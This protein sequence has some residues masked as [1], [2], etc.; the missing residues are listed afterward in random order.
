MMESA[1]DRDD[2]SESEIATSIE[3]KKKKVLFTPV[4]VAWLQ[5]LY[6]SGTR[7]TGERYLQSIAKA[8]K[9]TGLQIAQIKVCNYIYILTCS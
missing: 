7:G 5:V 9:D 6:A 4:Q 3:P 2:V 1:G 8:A